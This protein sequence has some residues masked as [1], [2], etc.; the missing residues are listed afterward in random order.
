MTHLDVVKD[1]D[2]DTS[3]LKELK[4]SFDACDSN[5]DGWIVNAEFSELLRTLDQDLSE[6]EC[7]LAFELTDQDGD[8]S[9]SFEEFMGWWT[10][11]A[12]L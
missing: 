7:L 4:Q 6:D 2:V 11:T 5:S 9:I 3:D 10:D 12:R 8:G 1:I